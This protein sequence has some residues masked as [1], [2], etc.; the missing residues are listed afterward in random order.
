MPDL[1]RQIRLAAGD[2]FMHGQ[3]HRM[4]RIG[5]PGNVCCAVHRLDG[6]LDADLLRR[7]IAE[8]PLLD[9]LARVRIVRRLPFMPPVWRMEAKPRTILY[10]HADSN[11]SGIEPWQLPKAVADRELHSGRGP[12]LTFD[13]VR[14]AGWDQPSL[15]LLEPRAA[16]CARRGPAVE[17]PEQRRHGEGR[18]V[19]RTFDQPEAEGLGFGRLV[20]QC[21]K[22]RADR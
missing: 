10:E 17:P 2:Y 22:R 18:T 1:P 21:R 15:S 12:S 11:G 4:R 3:D 9:W 13:L 20:A 8:S 6:G 19:H 14:H 5:L 16:R 7:R